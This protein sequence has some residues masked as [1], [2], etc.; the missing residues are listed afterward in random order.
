MWEISLISPTGLGF[1][2]FG[3]RHLQI[4]QKLP[5]TNRSWKEHSLRHSEK[6]TH[7]PSVD[8]VAF[9]PKSGPFWRKSSISPT[10]LGFFVF[11]LR[12]LQIVQELPGTI[13][14]WK[15]TSFRPFEIFTHWPPIK[16]VQNLPKKTKFWHIIDPRW[17]IE[18][19]QLDVLAKK[20]VTILGKLMLY[21]F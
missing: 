15:T 14:S 3:L 5:E 6:V 20:G 21:Q 16:T 17:P 7:W 19:I 18:H 4:A 13:C 9:W 2:I 8:T 10:G 1:F 11:E 12:H